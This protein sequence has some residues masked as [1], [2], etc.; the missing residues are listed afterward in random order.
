MDEDKL[1]LVCFARSYDKM[2]V[3]NKRI[4]LASS[5]VMS[6]YNIDLYG[7][8][9]QFLKEKMKRGMYR[10]TYYIFN[11]VD[12]YYNK[13]CLPLIDRFYNIENKKEG[14]YNYYDCVRVINIEFD[15]L[16]TLLEDDGNKL[17][18]TNDFI[19]NIFGN[20]ESKKK[21]L[22][23]ICQDSVFIFRNISWSNI[24]LLFKLKGIDI[25]GGS[26]SKRHILS[27]VDATLKEFLDLFYGYNTNFINKH[28]IYESFKAKDGYL[29]SLIDLNIYKNMLENNKC[30]KDTLQKEACWKDIEKISK[31][32]SDLDTAGQLDKNKYIIYNYIFIFKHL[33]KILI[34][35]YAGKNIKI[36]KNKIEKLKISL[37]KYKHEI[38]EDKKII[39]I[40]KASGDVIGVKQFE[41]NLSITYN[42]YSAIENEIKNLNEEISKEYNKIFEEINDKNL[43]Q[44]YDMVFK[45]ETV[46]NKIKNRGD[47]KDLYPRRTKNQNIVM[48]KREYST[49]S[50]S[51][52]NLSSASQQQQGS[53]INQI[54]TEI[55]TNPMYVKIS[56]ILKSPVAQQS[57]SN[58][59]KQ[60]QIE[61]TLRFFWNQELSK[62]FKGKDSLFR[63]AIGINILISSISK[64]DK[65]LNTIKEDKRYLKNKSYRNHI[66]ISE[67]GIIISIVLSNIIPHMMKYKSNQNTATLFERIGKDLHKILL[68]N[69]W[70]KYENIENST[71]KIYSCPLLEQ[72]NNN[73]YAEIEKGL[74]KEEFY[75]RLDEILGNIS[76]DDYFRLGC[77]LA[78]IVSENSNMFNFINVKNEEDNTVQRVVVPG[79]ELDEQ[80]IKL[81]AVE[82]DKLIMICEPCKWDVTINDTNSY[83]INRYGGFLLNSINK[84]D[85]ISKSQTNSGEIK[86]DNF[87]II[88]CINYLGS[89]P[90]TINTEVLKHLLN[91]IKDKDM[92]GKQA[93]L[94]KKINELIKLNMHHDTKNIFN[95]T[96]KKK[97]GELS[98]IYKHNSQFYG[99]KSI[100]T[101]ALLFSQWC[102][103]SKDNS[104]YFNYFIDWRGRLYTNT[105]YFSFQGGELARSL[106]MFKEGQVLTGKGLEN[107][108]I[109]TANCYGL[110]KLSYNQ[111]LEWTNNNLDK[112]ISVPNLSEYKLDFN[113]MSQGIDTM[114]TNFYNFM[115]EADEPLLFLSCCVELKNYY[116][117][118]T[119]FLSRL[120]VYLDATCNGLQHLS[121]MIND[122]NLAKFVNLVNSNKDEIPKDVY[123]HM[124]SFVNNKIQKYI[125]KDYSLAILG[126]ILINRKFIKPGI[127]TIAYGSTSRG[128]GDQLKINHFR[129]LDLV[130]GKKKA[131]VLINKEFNKTEF[132]IHLTLKQITV[133]AKA[134]HSVL[135]DVF[136]NLTILVKYLKDMNKMLKKLKL[137]T[138]WLTP[139]GL[140]IE[141]NYSPL[142]KREI[143]T[144]IL[145][146]RKSISLK[147]KNRNLTD[148]RKQNSA[149]VPN[150]V[151]SFDA[152]NIALL[153]KN[154]SSNFCDKKMNLLTIHDCFATNANDVEK[155]VLKV[156]LAFISLYSDKS[157][158]ESYHNFILDFIK[159][160][161]Y[162][163]IEKKYTTKE[164]INSYVVTDNE[165]IRIPKKP[166]FT[167]NK[168]LRFKILG[169]QY[170]I[171]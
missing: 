108:K 52:R 76:S 134:I 11:V 85:F 29:S 42:H 128:I 103:S 2:H 171:N 73:L 48:A 126:N 160:T 111:R 45:L 120:P 14:I 122:T 99:D 68:N 130:K 30:F 35:F 84:I 16:L 161:G 139:A 154:I 9:F 80:I 65:V 46:K 55:T 47:I 25:S 61:K 62:L 110:D 53:G 153:V 165:N 96:L 145:G 54:I 39:A 105:S 129:Q 93:H 34:A 5:V 40:S 91:L 151:H 56:Q 21:N 147:E 60:L 51:S 132:D 117:N 169:S 142:V 133:L 119:V 10:S 141:Q 72:N 23:S 135:Y 138:V 137:H 131:Y 13:D 58:R 94:Y 127:M 116:A 156:K 75:I 83:K 26:N 162:P 24:V 98:E 71:Q 164:D 113:Y 159:K 157:F 90:Y 44:V 146:R 79:K 150:I 70:D 41:E 125:E 33:V 170:F 15:S 152:S 118:P 22:D 114:S 144:S 43:D 143:T 69:E 87:N 19:T 6:S 95:Y 18:I 67:N 136:P 37:E 149:I 92:D 158:I 7:I 57:L 38:D 82:S 112:I 155:M 27:T 121:T 36:L 1:L 107:L 64:L 59:E 31:K 3:K 89:I 124:V 74:S 12:G 123:L 88:D 86:L 97:Y 106:L 109:Y 140:I 8:D 4:H 104:L 50:N 78:E 49:F 63:N 102:D 81:L 77:D 148:I 167:I 168:D 115:M 17:N 28:I 66:M 163:I 20:V 101:S 166:P 32:L 100:I